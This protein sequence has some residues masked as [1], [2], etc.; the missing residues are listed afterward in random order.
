MPADR[1]PKGPFAS[2]ALLGLDTRLRPGR[3]P[4]PAGGPSVQVGS[5][6]RQPSLHF[7]PSGPAVSVGPSPASERFLG[8]SQQESCVVAARTLATT[9]GPP[10]RSGCA[11][12][13]ARL[14]QSLPKPGSPRTGICYHYLPQPPMAEARFAPTRVSNSEGSRERLDTTR[15]LPRHRRRS[16]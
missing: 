16:E 3:Y 2:P 7:S 6:L 10:R 15:Q 9:A 13:T 1:Y 8:T 4:H 12:R 14:R 11:D 5:S